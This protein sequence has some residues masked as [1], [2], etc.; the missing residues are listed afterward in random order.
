[1]QIITILFYTKMMF[2]EKKGAPN[3][4]LPNIEIAYRYSRTG[5]ATIDE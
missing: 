2:F 5:L 4:M 1:M 3:P